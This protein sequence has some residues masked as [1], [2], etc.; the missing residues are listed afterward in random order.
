MI[1]EVTERADRNVCASIVEILG[2]DQV[3][4]AGCGFRCG[5]PL[6]G[7]LRLL[8]F[9]DLLTDGS[10][11]GKCASLILA[12]VLVALSVLVVGDA[13]VSEFLIAKVCDLVWLIYQVADL[14]RRPVRF[15]KF[16]VTLVVSFLEGAVPTKR[17]TQ[18]ILD[19][20]VSLVAGLAHL[21]E[22]LLGVGRYPLLGTCGLLVACPCHH[23]T[24]SEASQVFLLADLPLIVGVADEIV[25]LIVGETVRAGVTVGDCSDQFLGVSRS[26]TMS[27]NVAP[28]GEFRCGCTPIQTFSVAGYLGELGVG[29]CLHLLRTFDVASIRDGVPALVT[30][31]RIAGQGDLGDVDVEAITGGGFLRRLGLNGLHRFHDA[32]DLFLLRRLLGVGLVLDLLLRRLGLLESVGAG[33]VGLVVVEDELTGG[34]GAFPTAVQ[35]LALDVVTVTDLDT[36]RVRRHPAASAGGRAVVVDDG[37]VAG[38]AVLVLDGFDVEEGA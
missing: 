15:D 34:V 27:H 37:D 14:L 2:L 30:L 4:T 31:D 10:A 25:D 6:L 17:L 20:T 5:I 3:N 33:Q 35:F 21:V 28:A 11:C 18:R 13:G 7:L 36:D 1:L 8:P 24:D 26:S 16:G 19:V 23:S 12:G 29:A 32:V 9:A 38:V 22:I